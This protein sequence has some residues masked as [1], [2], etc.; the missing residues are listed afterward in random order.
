[1]HKYHILLYIRKHPQSNYHI[2]RI[3]LQLP[4]YAMKTVS[5]IIS[6]FTR[7]KL[8]TLHCTEP[9]YEIQSLILQKCSRRG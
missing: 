6:C 8:A 3:L 5:I 7:S 2:R 1:M 9:R 4:F